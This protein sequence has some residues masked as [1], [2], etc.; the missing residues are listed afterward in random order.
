MSVCFKV[1]IFSDS[2]KP[3][4]FFLLILLPLFFENLAISGK[5]Y[6]K[7]RDPSSFLVNRKKKKNDKHLH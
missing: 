1:Y 7:K 6:L 5:K 3:V 4:K 2:L